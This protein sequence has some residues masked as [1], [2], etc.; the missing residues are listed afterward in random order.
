MTNI[1][2]RSQPLLPRLLGMVAMLSVHIFT[3]FL[4]TVEM[5]YIVP[6]HILFFDQANVEMPVAT[7]HVMDISYN[8][9]KFWYLIVFLGTIADAAVLAL[10]TFV[11][12]KKKWLL[13]LYS[14]LWLISIILLLVYISIG[15]SLPMESLSNAYPIGSP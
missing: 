7:I 10:L 11:V 8:F 15:L 9:F 6:M 14:H 1:D 3:M 4:V 5:V 2:S 13:P 12:T